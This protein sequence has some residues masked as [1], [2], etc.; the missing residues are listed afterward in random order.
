MHFQ[1][2][3]KLPTIPS[4]LAAL[5]HNL[6]LVVTLFYRAKSIWNRMGRTSQCERVGKQV[7][8]HHYNAGRQFFL[9]HELDFS[10]C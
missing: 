7:N 8:H 6:H 4:L 1:K 9:F 10:F 5:M 3:K 2:E